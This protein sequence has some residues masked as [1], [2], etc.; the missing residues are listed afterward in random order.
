ML[1]I[2]KLINSFLNINENYNTFF[3]GDLDYDHKIQ[4]Q[5]LELEL[6]IR[7]YFLCDT[8]CCFNNHNIK[9]IVKIMNF[10]V[11]HNDYFELINN[12]I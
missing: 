9:N 5:I 10:N 7:K 12:S 1:I 2:L 8:W 11:N 6:D 4:N 3:L